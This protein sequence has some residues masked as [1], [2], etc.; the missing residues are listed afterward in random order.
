MATIIRFTSDDFFDYNF[1]QMLALRHSI[2]TVDDEVEAC[3]KFSGVR[4]LFGT[5][6]IGHVDARADDG[7]CR[8]FLLYPGLRAVESL[9]ALDEAWDKSN[10]A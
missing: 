4:D 10:A 2:Y 8:V 9:N 1:A 5:D 3:G 6:C 7:D